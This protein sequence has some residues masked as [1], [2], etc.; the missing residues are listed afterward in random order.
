MSRMSSQRARAERGGP[1]RALETPWPLPIRG[2]F[3]DAKDSEIRS[4]AEVMNNWT[5]NGFSLDLRDGYEL[6]SPDSVLQRIPFEFG[7]TPDYINVL[8]DRITYG[9]INFLGTFGN[10]VSHTAIS[11][12]IIMADGANPILR[13]DGANIVDAAITTDTGKPSSEFDGIFSHQDRLYAWDSSELA[14]YYGAV[15]AVTGQLVKFPLDALGNI[16]GNIALIKSVTVNAAHGMNDI[17]VIVTSTGMVVL[18]EGLDPGDANDWRLLGRFQ[19]SAPV[20]KFAVVNIGSDLWMLTVRGLV[21]IKDA[22]ANGVR[23]ITSPTVRPIADLLVTDIQAYKSQRGWQMVARPDDAQVFLNVPTATGFK[24]YVFN[25]NVGS[26]ETTDYPAKWWTDAF[27]RMDFTGTDGRLYSLTQGGGDNGADI[28]A[29]FNTAWVRLPRYRRM[30]FHGIAYIIPTII[31]DGE[32]T[33]K[34]TVLTDHDQTSTDISEAQQTVTIKPD[35]PGA[36]VALN[37]I[38]AINAL[39]RVFQVRFEVTG[40]NISFE[41]LM[42]GLV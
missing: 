3:S 11:S 13:C 8:S 7:T 35:A 14:F 26:W 19:T 31:A 41:K 16:N 15:G 6:R 36:G 21:S 4:F 17:L 32:L 34:I 37:D 42:A 28:T 2:L 25:V 23:A 38:I 20:S 30:V 12:N 39:G 40:K 29:T 5:S 33:V 9:A 22:L 10:D 18:Y 24:Q 1:N 27:G